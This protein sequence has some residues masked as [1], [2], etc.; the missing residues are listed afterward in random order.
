MGRASAGRAADESRMSPV[1]VG[2]VVSHPAPGAPKAV[3]T[4]FFYSGPPDGGSL[5]CYR[6]KW[7]DWPNPA[8]RTE[9][10][11]DTVGL[12]EDEI[13]DEDFN[14]GYYYAWGVKVFNGDFSY[15]GITDETP[16]VYVGT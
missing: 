10:E 15:T 3:I 9:Y 11:V 5:Y 13:E 7:T 6:A 2:A 16:A 4:W 12:D 1:S 14:D 8:S